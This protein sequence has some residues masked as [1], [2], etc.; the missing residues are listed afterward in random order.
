M[1]DHL[2]DGIQELNVVTDAAK[3]LV[4]ATYEDFTA[5]YGKNW[6]E[7]DIKLPEWDDYCITGIE[8]AY[9]NDPGQLPGGVQ[10]AVY[11]V[12]YEF[13]SPT[14]ENVVR[15]GGVYV[16]DDGWAGGFWTGDSPYLVFQIVD[17]GSYK[18]LENRISFD[19]NPDWPG[20][21]GEITTTLMLNQ[22]LLPSE[23]SGEMLFLGVVSS[24]DAFAD[25]L[26]LYPDSEQDIA[27]LK[28][29]E[30]LDYL[31]SNGYYKGEYLRE[32]VEMTE[33]HCSEDGAKVME[34]LKELMVNPIS[35]Q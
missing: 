21:D 2:L 12:D 20:F 3:A 26:A 6:D 11:E 7:S 28:L 30:H 24:P 14:P 25:A 34:R 1:N 35:V 19:M 32:I 33:A 10:L 17:D 29:L 16:C 4:K 22:L 9:M 8:C 18:L 13:H 31:E 27:L 23:A 5:D 15:A